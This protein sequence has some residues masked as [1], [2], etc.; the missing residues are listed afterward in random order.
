[1][2]SDETGGQAVE[3]DPVTVAWYQA[4]TAWDAQIAE[5]A[6]KRRRAVEHIQA[7]MGEATE[8][9]IG[10]RPVVTWKPSKPA[11]YID[12]KAL[13]RDLPDI[14]ARYTKLKAAARPFKIL[15]GDT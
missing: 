5:L 6:D 10:G 11:E 8:A 2:S 3:L 7:V 14:A 15:N 12:K 4:I 1:M 13:E 9:R